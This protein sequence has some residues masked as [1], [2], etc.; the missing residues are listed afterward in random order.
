M[1]KNLI[2][3][4]IA[5]FTLSSCKKDEMNP[6]I[7]ITSPENQ[8]EI[9]WGSLIDVNASFSD[10]R[11]LA[12]YHIHIGNEEGEHV[13]DFP[14][15]AE[16]NISGKEYAYQGQISIPD[17]IE[18]IYYLHFEVTDAEGKTSTDKLMLQFTP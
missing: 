4:I 11:E 15:E 18:A 7:S 17:S 3:I 14:W 8:S 2:T 6:V 12:S 16:E 9:H 5:V 13:H 10:D 1:K